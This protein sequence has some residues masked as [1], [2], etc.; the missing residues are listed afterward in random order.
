MNVELLRKIAAVIQEKPREFSMKTWHKRK[1]SSATGYLD[2]LPK[3]KEVACGTTHCIA[4]WA[5]A[6][7]PNRKPRE[8]ALD[9][10]KRVLRLTDDQATLLFYGGNWPK[11]FG[12]E[13]A[14]ASK[15]AARIEHFIETG[16]L[17]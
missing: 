5:Q 11:G 13:R 16:G 2:A 17:E 9:D 10:A 12:G 3:G 15:A 4:G 7:A 6:L 1:G 14:T 8:W